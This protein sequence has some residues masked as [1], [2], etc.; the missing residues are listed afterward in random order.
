MSFIAEGGV[1]KRHYEWLMR[2]V[3]AVRSLPG[4][5][6]AEKIWGYYLSLGF[7][8]AQLANLREFLLEPKCD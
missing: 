8:A 6:I 1:D 4:N 3:S 7:K 5:T 2:L